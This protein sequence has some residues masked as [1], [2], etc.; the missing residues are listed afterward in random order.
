MLAVKEFTV[1]QISLSANEL[2][3]SFE[4]ESQDPLNFLFQIYRSESQG[5][6]FDAVSPEFT[7]KFYYIDNILPWPNPGRTLFYKLKQKDQASNEEFSEIRYIGYGNNLYALEIAR[8]ERA[9]FKQAAGQKLYIFPVKTFGKF[10]SCYDSIT[11]KRFKKNCQECYETGFSGGYMDVIETYGQVGTYSKQ[12]RELPSPGGIELDMAATVIKLVNYPIVKRGD[13]ILDPK[14]NKRW[15]AATIIPKN[16]AG[17][18]VSQ[19]ITAVLLEP[20]NMAYTLELANYDIFQVLEP[21]LL[22]KQQTKF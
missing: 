18:L 21:N 16:L 5:G 22:A 14:Y 20:S 1:R 4:Q 11:G 8:L 9:A 7:N 13:I 6:P 17:C 19:E 15:R 10:C 2:T 3:W 12:I